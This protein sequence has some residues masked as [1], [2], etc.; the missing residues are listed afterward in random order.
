VPDCGMLDDL[1]Q[2][3]RAYRRR[4]CVSLQHRRQR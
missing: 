1:V 2:R 3:D 4:W